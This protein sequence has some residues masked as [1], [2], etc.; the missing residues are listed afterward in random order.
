M[1]QL[2]SKIPALLNQGRERCRLLTITL[3]KP[4]LTF[5]VMSPLAHTLWGY[6]AVLAFSGYVLRQA[7]KPDKW[8][9][10]IFARAMNKSH[11][12]M[13]T[14]GLDHVIIE[15]QFRVLD[16]GCGGGRTIAKLAAI[17]SAG[18]V[19]GIDYAEGSVAVARG[20]NANLIEAGRVV[21]QKASVS[22]LPFPDNT[23]DRVTAIE[24]QYY[25]PDLK[26]DMREILRVL[27]PGGRLVVI[28]ETYKGG[29]YDRFKWP[30]MWL[31]RSSH[32]S[33]S[34]H[35]ELF[36]SAGYVNIEIFEEHNRGWICGVATKPSL[37]VLL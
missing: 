11:D 21:I 7:R 28:A 17:A 37:A 31:L 16:I 36:A 29:K 8:F 22:K 26:G 13:T 3:T 2:S 12:A 20:Y 30:V 18:V 35:R 23:F 27:R 4:K 5:V 19:D 1:R 9:G 25:W 32:L 24:T 33:V 15:R 6:A 10:R 14:W 34:D